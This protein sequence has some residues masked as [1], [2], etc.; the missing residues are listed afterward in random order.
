VGNVEE[1][2]RRREYSK[3]MAQR[4][5]RLFKQLASAKADLTRQKEDAQKARDAA[6]AEGA[7]IQSAK[8]KVEK[9][10]ADQQVILGHVQGQLVAAVAQERA[11]RE[12]AARALFSA[13]AGP[14]SYPNVGPPNGSASQ[15]IAFARGVLG[16]PYS[17]NPR[18]GPSYDCSGLTYSAWHAAGIEIPKVSGTQ[19]AG[20]PHVPLNAIQ[21]GDLLFWGPGGSQHVALY[22][23]NGTII[24]ASSS[25]GK[26][27][28]RGIW[29]NPIGAA[30]VT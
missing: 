30:R 27:V 13:S 20:L 18:F 16:A 8:S 29:G 21:P 2:S 23:G 15:A 4:D 6:A 14:V 12:A 19:Y 7:V 28:E 1:L 24:D 17:T 11:A 5:N 26:V 22:V 3:V 9:A 25:Q 10:K